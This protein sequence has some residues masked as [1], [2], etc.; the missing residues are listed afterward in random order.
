M[1]QARKRKD[2]DGEFVL[3]ERRLAGGTVT[4]KRE[5]VPNVI[6]NNHINN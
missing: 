2:Y 4:E 3:V 5:W 6:S 1:M